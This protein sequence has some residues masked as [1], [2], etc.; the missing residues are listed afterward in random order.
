MNILWLGRYRDEMIQYI[1][2]FG[3]KVYITNEPIHADLKC[4]RDADFLISYGYRYIIRKSVLDLFPDKVINLHISLLPWN[5]GADPNLWSFL[6]DTPKGVTIHMIDEGID[7]GN[8]L[9]QKEVHFFI[10]KETLRTSYESLSVEMEDLFIKNWTKIKFQEIIATPQI[11]T[12]SFHKSIDK[13]KYESLLRNGWDTPV[14]ILH[15]QAL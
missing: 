12:G 2:S 7:T 1:E 10:N 3:D 8:I 5:R 13:K 11:G 4:V 6:E 9:L 14:K 15:R